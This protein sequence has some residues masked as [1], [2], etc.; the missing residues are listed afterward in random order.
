ML[1]QPVVKGDGD[2]MDAWSKSAQTTP[3][4]VYLCALRYL[5]PH[6]CH[7]AV[8]QH[9]LI[10][11]H[12]PRQLCDCQK[13][14]NQE[15]ITTVK[16]SNFDST[17]TVLTQG[18]LHG[19]DTCLMDWTAGV[20]PADAHQE[21]PETPPVAD[22][23]VLESATAPQHCAAAVQLRHCY[24]AAQPAAPPPA[25]P[26]TLPFQG[27]QPVGSQSVQK[28]DLSSLKGTLQAETHSLSVAFTM[29][30]HGSPGWQIDS[31]LMSEQHWCAHDAVNLLE[32]QVN[33]VVELLRCT[34]C[35]R[36]G[37]DAVQEA[38]VCC[39]C[40]IRERPA[41]ADTALGA[42]WTLRQGC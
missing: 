26:W 1:P 10:V 17:C 11:W 34:L 36:H 37:V 35:S 19:Y 13:A 39:F 6:A 12:F 24:P 14:G 29:D 18:H 22:P 23:A 21:A 4:K 27:A 38:A 25:L 33:I 30:L 3:S 2:R 16:T 7:T 42:M 8:G 28:A 31:Q 5:Q 15:N 40:E 9:D 32:K 20:K 41:A